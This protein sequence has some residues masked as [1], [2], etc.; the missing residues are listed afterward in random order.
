MAIIFLLNNYLS[1][2]TSTDM[3]SSLIYFYFYS[4]LSPSA[5]VPILVPLTPLKIISNPFLILLSWKTPVFRRLIHILHLCQL[6]WHLVMFLSIF[7]PMSRKKNVK[8]ENRL[9]LAT[10]LKDHFYSQLCEVFC[11]SKHCKQKCVKDSSKYKEDLKNCREN[12]SVDLGFQTEKIWCAEFYFRDIIHIVFNFK[13]EK[14]MKNKVNFP[15]C[16]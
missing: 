9:S 1:E 5:V 2:D 7:A 15:F 14:S 3:L 13:W 10:Y 16:V 11:M 4:F 6:C 12:Y 8:K